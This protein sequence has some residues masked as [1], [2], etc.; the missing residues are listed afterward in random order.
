MLLRRIFQLLKRQ[1]RAGTNSTLFSEEHDSI[2][3]NSCVSH[4]FSCDIANDTPPKRMRLPEGNSDINLEYLLPLKKLLTCSVCLE[5]ARQ[6]CQCSNGHL[7]CLRC[8]RRLE[9]VCLSVQRGGIACVCPTCRESLKVRANGR[10]LQRSLVAEQ[11]A[12][13]LPASCRYCKKLFLLKHLESHQQLEC[14]ERL[15]SC[16]NSLFGCKWTGVYKDANQ[17]V[18]SC[19]VFEQSNRALVAQ[20]Q[21]LLEDV[22]KNSSDR[23]SPWRGLLNILEEREQD[24]FGK[25]YN[26]G[27]RVITQ[28][29]DLDRNHSDTENISFI[30]KPVRIPLVG[31]NSLWINVSLK[32]VWSKS[33]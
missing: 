10:G 27:Y 22:F 19:P 33:F 24:R 26:T 5:P 23:L 30:S 15:V 13:E 7:I 16:K 32:Y 25:R 4:Q 18:S 31:K 9:Q 28:N 6:A 29:I 11:L 20:A 17:H 8:A 21:S 1:F 2:R 12:L 14:E 3:N